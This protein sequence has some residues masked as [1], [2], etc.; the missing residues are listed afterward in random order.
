[1]YANNLDNLG[2]VTVNKFLETQNLPRLN[3]KL[4]ESLNRPINRKKSESVIKIFQQRKSLKLITSLG[5]SAKNVKND[6][7]FQKNLKKRENVLTYFL[8]PA[9]FQC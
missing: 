7:I 8:K 3:H 1:M 6:T 9:L 5:N 2:T 4:I